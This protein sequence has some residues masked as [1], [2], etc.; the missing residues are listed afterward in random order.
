MVEVTV[1]E[2]IEKIVDVPVVKQ[3]EVPQIQ[4]IEKIVEVPFVQVVEK[5]VE[6]PQ[7]GQTL[8][9]TTTEQHVSLEP[10]RQEH[11]A[12]VV[13]QV[14]AGPDLPHEYQQFGTIAQEINSM[15]AETYYGELPPA[16]GSSVQA[17][18]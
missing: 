6:V 16:T 14:L 4:T 18:A 10:Q 7:V 15:P 17:T 1:I 9:G 11:P 8:Q 3:L 12:Q 13:Q 5:V 2:T